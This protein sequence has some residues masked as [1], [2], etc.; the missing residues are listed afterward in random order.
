MRLLLL[1]AS[2]ASLPY[3]TTP[4]AALKLKGEPFVIEGG[5]TEVAPGYSLIDSW[6]TPPTS[7]LFES[8][9]GDIAV[10]FP[11][12]ANLKTSLYF[13][14]LNANGSQKW[15]KTRVRHSP[16]IHQISERRA[17]FG[18][19]VIE[20]PDGAFLTSY[21]KPISSRSTGLYTQKVMNGEKIGKPEV[22][23][24]S[25]VTDSPSNV[26]PELDAVLVPTSKAG[27]MIWR[28]R[29]DDLPP[30]TEAAAVNQA[31]NVSA[32]SRKILGRN[33]RPW[34]VAAEGSGFAVAYSGR[35]FQKNYKYQ[36][37]DRHGVP[38]GSSTI[39]RK[40]GEAGLGS[41]G[42]V[43]LSNGDTACFLVKNLPNDGGSLT[44]V[45]IRDASGTIVHPAAK[46]APTIARYWAV[47]GGFVIAYATSSSQSRY[48]VIERYNGSVEKVGATVTVPGWSVFQVLPLTNG[49]ALVAYSKR[50]EGEPRREDLMGQFLSP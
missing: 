1:A 17:L 13:K 6:Y 16:V 5:L 44:F 48:T 36:A 42:F 7:I 14:L 23:V 39:L 18:S 28:A 9:S 34:Q 24:K 22:I 33:Q 15:A 19:G 47:P 21:T 49:D 45:E 8:R 10:F 38:V 25:D 32:R 43:K 27:T 40:S 2:M 11:D 50:L 46:V 41:F 3:A 29:A 35:R 30:L 31:G 12:E 4:A 37:F 20:L 26:Y